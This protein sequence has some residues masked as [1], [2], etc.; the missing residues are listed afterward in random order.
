MMIRSSG[1]QL[2]TGILIKINGLKTYNREYNGLR[3]VFTFV[4]SWYNDPSDQS[5][6]T[7]DASCCNSADG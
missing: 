3:G 5:G 1:K 7:Q 4:S 6:F 2:I